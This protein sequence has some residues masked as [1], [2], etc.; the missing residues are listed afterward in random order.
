MPEFTL[1]SNGESAGT[2]RDRDFLLNQ[3]YLLSPAV[4]ADRFSE[5][6]LRA[7]IGESIDLLASP[8][9]LMLKSLLPRD[10]TGELIA[11][12]SLQESDTRPAVADGVWV[13]RDGTRALLLAQTRAS[14]ADTDGQQRCAGG[15]PPGVRRGDRGRSRRRARIPP[16]GFRTR[17]VRGVVAPDHT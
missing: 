8:A 17:R 2:E 1:V 14:G 7:A 9:G 5:A 13:S 6:G 12:L 4:T 11:L 10:P 15:D 3:R 16:A